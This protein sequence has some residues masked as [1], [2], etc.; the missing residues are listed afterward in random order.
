MLISIT[1]YYKRT[2][3]HIIDILTRRLVVNSKFTNHLCETFFRYRETRE[4]RDFIMRVIYILANLSMGGTE[5]NTLCL[6][7]AMQRESVDTLLCTLSTD[8]EGLLAE[9]ARQAGIKRIT[10]GRYQQLAKPGLWPVNQPVVLAFW[11]AHKILHL[12]APFLMATALASNIVLV[13]SGP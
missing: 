11:V 13:I 2:I 6:M 1:P 3:I 4:I 8:R 5:A 12:I 7:Q 10:A 9:E